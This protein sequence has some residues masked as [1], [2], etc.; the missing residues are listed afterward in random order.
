MK[1]LFYMQIL[2]SSALLSLFLTPADFRIAQKLGAIDTPR[3]K[4]RMHKSAVPRLGGL[5]ILVS[6]LVFSLVFDLPDLG[7]LFFGL[8]GGILVAFVGVLDDRFS[9]SPAIKLLAQSAGA[10]VSMLGGNLV[11]SVGGLSVG[12]LAVPLT[13]LWI[14]T[15]VNAHNFIDGLDGL[16]AGIST[17][18]AIGLGLIAFMLG[19]T[20]VLVCALTLGGACLGFLPYNARGAKI[21]MGDTGSTTVGFLLA[22]LSVKL[23][24]S[25]TPISPV[26]PSLLFI[27]P[28]ADITFAVTRRLLAGKNPFSPD[29]SHIHHFAADHLGHHAASRL[30][31]FL[32]A[33]GSALAF[34]AA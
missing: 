33:L 9:L 27:L 4:R 28:L 17:A 2:V 23:F 7:H 31:C 18:E 32:A 19:D 12:V 25:G 24:F 8:A 5:S 15:L 29:R 10:A 34:L 6:F 22:F 3:D 21:F 16:C 11:R 14:L 1:I 26:V 13:L 20:E 30:L